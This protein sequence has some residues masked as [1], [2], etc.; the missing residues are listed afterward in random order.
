MR[1]AYFA[2]LSTEPLLW[3]GESRFKDEKFRWLHLI[4][5]RSDGKGLEQVRAELGVIAAQID[6][7][8]ASAGRRG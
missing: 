4:G 7:A 2:P 8:A 5:R 3:P 1:T 6:R